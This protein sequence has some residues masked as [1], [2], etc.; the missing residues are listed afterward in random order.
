V[1][2]CEE[3]DWSKIGALDAGSWFSS[4]FAGEPPIDLD[5]ALAI[6]RPHVP[7]IVEVKPVGRE[8]ER[9]VDPA[10]RETVEA[11]LAA[12][13]RTGGLRGVTMS[14]AGWSILAH[15]AKH[16]RGLDIALTVG[17]ME[18]RDPIAWAARI[19][20]TALHPNRRL[21]TPAFVGRARGMGLLVIPYTVNRVSEL[22]PLLDTGVDGVF[23]D[24]PAGL[25]RLL[26]RRAGAEDTSGDLTMG[27]DQ[28]SGGTRAVL[29]DASGAIVASQGTRVASRGTRA[30]R[31][32]RTP[33]RS[34][35]R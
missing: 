28:G 25:R 12:F 16:V 8:R 17:S 2:R 1:G 24:D 4:R 32:S 7:L 18:R 26:S 27:I 21:C 22:D 15:A 6:V 13:E 29:I 5:D 20:A 11:I 23:T 33:W 31:S 35:S 30:A 19:G 9:G 14:S 3:L 10:D 34:W